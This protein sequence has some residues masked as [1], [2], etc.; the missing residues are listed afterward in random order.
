MTLLHCQGQ[1]QQANRQSTQGADGHTD[2]FTVLLLRTG[3]LPPAACTVPLPCLKKRP[4]QNRGLSSLGL[5]RLAHSPA[6]EHLSATCDLAK[7]PV[8]T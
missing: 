5:A 2:T 6:F 4:P 1:S 7:W 8:G 3:S